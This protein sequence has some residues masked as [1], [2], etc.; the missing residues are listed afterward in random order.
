MLCPTDDELF[1]RVEGDRSHPELEAHIAGC[2][3]CQLFLA[4]VRELPAVNAISDAEVKLGVDAVLHRVEASRRGRRF[5]PLLALAAALALLLPG[6]WLFFLQP[7]P[8]EDAMTPRGTVEPR[9]AK[10]ILRKEVGFSIH[11]ASAPAVEVVAGRHYPANTRWVGTFRNQSTDDAFALVF[12]VDSQGTRH[13]LYP[14]HLS[15]AAN[16]RA[17]R[18]PRL[19]SASLGEQVELED[20][21]P[22]PMT[23]FTVLT[24]VEHGVREIESLQ[25]V[26]VSVLENRLGP[27]VTVETVGVI[28]E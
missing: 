15:D 10:T 12:A 25:V 9:E 14:A 16:E 2:S 28:L 18:L 6:A 27:T 19:S 1:A 5:A 22:G 23:L 7:H 8:A 17:V 3:Q 21:A 20:P 11:D 26:D 24:R 4:A 13:W